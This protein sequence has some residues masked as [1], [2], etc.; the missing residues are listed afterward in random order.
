MKKFLLINTI[1]L[2]FLSM[3]AMA[4]VGGSDLQNFNPT[5]NGTDFITV[6]SANVL[7]SGQFNFGSFLTYTL[8]SLPYSTL[9]ASPN[10]QSFSSPNDR[11]LNSNLH[12]AVGLMQG[13][14]IGVS[15]GFTN[16]Q[17]YERNDFLFN[18]GD[19]GINDVLVRSKIRL[20]KARRGLLLLLVGL[21]LIK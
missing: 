8:N 7:S 5:P 10:Q 17:D 21:I 13:W 18:Y 19:T 9:S 12:V 14:D 15:A 4:N 3:N 1:F 20:Y 2:C 11:I 6:H 16:S